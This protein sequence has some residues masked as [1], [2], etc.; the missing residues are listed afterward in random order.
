MAVPKRKTSQGRRDRRRAHDAITPLPSRSTKRPSRY[1][2][3]TTLTCAPVSTVAVKCSSK[4]TT[5]KNNLTTPCVLPL[6]PWE[7]MKHQRP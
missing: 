2:A 5:K 7:E 6:M 4:K 3:H 1:I